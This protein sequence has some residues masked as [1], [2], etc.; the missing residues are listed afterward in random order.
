MALGTT[1]ASL[2]LPPQKSKALD[3]NVLVLKNKKCRDIYIA[4][5]R[6]KRRASKKTS[7][8]TGK[9]LITQ[10]RSA[11]RKGRAIVLMV[12]GNTFPSLTQECLPSQEEMLSL[13]VKALPFVPDSLEQKK[14]RRNFVMP[15][16]TAR[17][18]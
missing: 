9:Q 10:N 5:R 13:L 14:L 18:P 1:A 4:K 12:S 3:N 7:T 17:V 15:S 16:R 6:A 2:M 8:A 11:P